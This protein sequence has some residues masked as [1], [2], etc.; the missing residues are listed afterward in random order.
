MAT[1]E[2]GMDRLAARFLVI[3]PG[4]RFHVPTAWWHLMGPF[5]EEDCI[6]AAEPYAYHALKRW[7]PWFAGKRD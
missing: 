5:R 7:W 2:S 4:V 1:S 6:H 3:L